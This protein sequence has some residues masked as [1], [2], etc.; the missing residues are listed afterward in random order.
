MKNVVIALLLL[1]ALAASAQE[2]D[3]NESPTPPAAA[4]TA[5]QNQ[6][7]RSLA[8]V[9]SWIIGR[10]EG[11]GVSHSERKFIGELSIKTDL[12]E[13]VLVFARESRNKEGGLSGGL[14]EIMILGVDGATKNIVGTMYDNA[15]GIVLYVGK[16]YDQEIVL[17]AAVSQPGFVNR[18]ILKLESE[19]HLS[20][21]I[22]GATSGKEVSKLVEIHFE[23]KS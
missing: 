14:K 20:F 19:D 3:E 8:D 5:Q 13:K 16:I 12:D 1:F 15:N 9:L 7:E 11:E 4:V 22:E 21:V 18:R 10:W 17:E 2:S 6:A 23:K